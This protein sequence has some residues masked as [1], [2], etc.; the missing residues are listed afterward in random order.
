MRRRP[1][2]ASLP[3]RA[4]IR[5]VSTRSLGD[6]T[7]ESP[8]H[9]RLT[10]TT[11]PM[12][13]TTRLHGQGQGVPTRTAPPGRRTTPGRDRRQR[14]ADRCRSIHGCVHQLSTRA[15]PLH[16]NPGAVSLGHGTAG[17]TRS[18]GD[19]SSDSYNSDGDGTHTYTEE[20]ARTTHGR[21]DRR[22]MAP[23]S[24][25]MPWARPSQRAGGRQSR[26]S[27]TDKDTDTGSEHVH[28]SGHGQ[29]VHGGLPAAL[30]RLGPEWAHRQQDEERS[31]RTGQG[32]ASA[33]SARE[34]SSSGQAP[35]SRSR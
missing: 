35:T 32:D 29:P 31:G 4:R 25:A 10:N 6:A 26:A 27:V 1:G 24:V 13:R 14:G 15:A 28:R 20:R 5:S 19:A 18:R 8:H 17:P 30:R 34:R 23:S 3:I 12:A 9:K 2:A 22:R 21:L 33:T 16:L 11:T 7:S